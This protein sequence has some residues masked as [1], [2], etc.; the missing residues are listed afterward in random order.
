MRKIALFVEGK[1]ELIFVR[2]YLCHWFDWQVDISCIEMLTGYE[3]S[4]FPPDN[5][6]PQADL[7][8]LIINVG[9]GAGIL[10][11]VK[12]KQQRLKEL[13]YEKIICLADM[14]DEDYK[15]IVGEKN[16]HQTIDIA[17][18]QVFIDAKK[19][20][21][22]SINAPLAIAFCY[23]IMEIEAWF[24]GKM[25]IF[26][27]INAK[28]TPH[29]LS[30]LLGKDIT[31]ID[32]ETTF[33]HPSNQIKQIFLSIGKKYNKQDSDIYKIVSIFGKADYQSLLTAKKCN[34]FNLFHEQIVS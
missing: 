9:G 21:I 11:Q 6:C 5:L 8:V 20:S 22:E 12:R 33:F 25:D 17:T 27:K 29:F 28:L 1:T 18:N 32:P 31:Q 19:E 14:Y 23:A 4:P 2:E 26:H 3:E 13:G 16:M 7:H 30:N 15:R 34:S 24:L 10:S